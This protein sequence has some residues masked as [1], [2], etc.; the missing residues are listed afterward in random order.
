MLGAEIRKAELAVLGACMLTPRAFREAAGIVNADCF[1]DPAHRSIWLG[2]LGLD[3][4]HK[5]TADIR[6]LLHKLAEVK[7]DLDPTEMVQSM[8]MCADAANVRYYAG[9]VR[10]AHAHRQLCRIAARLKTEIFES[11]S[12]EQAADIAGTAIGDLRDAL[13]AGA[14]Q[15][16][17]ATG[18]G[19]RS[20]FGRG[21][22]ERLPHVLACIESSYTG[23]RRGKLGII[24]ARH[25]HGKTAY[26]CA[27]SLAVACEGGRVLMQV[28][29]ELPRPDIEKRLIA[30]IAQMPL[31][32]VFDGG[33][34]HPGVAQ[35]MREFE[36]LDFTIWDESRPW[37]EILL[38]AQA[39]HAD[40][41]IDL[42]VFDYVQT[43]SRKP[44][45]VDALVRA[46]AKL[47]ADTGMAVVACSQLNRYADKNYKPT[48][49]PQ[50]GE[51]M[52]SATIEQAAN[53]VHNLWLPARHGHSEVRIDG[54][55]FDTRR[56]CELIVAK[57]ADGP[58]GHFPVR[59]VGETY[60]YRDWNV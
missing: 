29:P 32:D 49:R 58:T 27:Q 57:N 1:F 20:L 44:E 52:N 14:I 47:A 22:P 41:K 36:S 37:Q 6:L 43:V 24:G 39:A 11:C 45:V 48:G 34:E 2:F 55:P 28:S 3:E 56:L 51:H 12:W 17:P 33:L 46:L 19:F 26:A 50:D 59:F 18:D 35:A 9:I 10:Q 53:V 60:T 4:D 13:A 31:R 8:E 23:F 54:M 42:F 21:R 40:R 25:S 7:P 38:A 30:T 15:N 5:P 16:I